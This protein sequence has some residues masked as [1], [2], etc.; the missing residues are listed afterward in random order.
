MSNASQLW[1]SH[2]DKRVSTRFRALVQ[3]HG[4]VELQL[5]ERWALAIS[6]QPSDPLTLGSA[7]KPVPKEMCV[8]LTARRS[9]ST[10][11]L[12]LLSLR[13]LSQDQPLP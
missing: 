3:E 8:C 10:K 7:T 5:E 2:R 1:N 9:A 6:P 13:L 12:L 4:N 11:T